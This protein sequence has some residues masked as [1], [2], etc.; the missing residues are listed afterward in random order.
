MACFRNYEQIN[1]TDGSNHFRS[2]VVALRSKSY[3]RDGDDYS[4]YTSAV[5]QQLNDTA[6]YFEEDSRG[7]LYIFKGAT[8]FQVSFSWPHFPLKGVPLTSLVPTTATIGGINYSDVFILNGTGLTDLRNYIKKIWYSKSR[9]ILQFED[10]AGVI[11]NRT[12]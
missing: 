11:W 8:G 2:Y 3:Q 1:F 7:Q 4:E 9:G 12:I 5:F 10:T 6:A